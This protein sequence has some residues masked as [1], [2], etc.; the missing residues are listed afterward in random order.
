MVGDV[1]G[2]Q[3]MV[4]TPPAAA[5]WLAERASRG[6][7]RR[8]ADEG[9]HVDQARR[10]HLAAAIDD[11]GAFGHAGRTNAFLRLADHAFRDQQIA[12]NIEIA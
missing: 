12:D 3:I 6:W 8:F 1:S 5:A 2:W 9:A 7:L 10:D 11:V 4:V